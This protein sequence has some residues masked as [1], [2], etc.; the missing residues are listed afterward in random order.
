MINHITGKKKKIILFWKQFFNTTDSRIK[1]C[2]FRLLSLD[3]EVFVK[4]FQ[5]QY[6]HQIIIII[7]ETHVKNVKNQQKKKLLT[8]QPMWINHEYES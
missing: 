6:Y 8:H 1:W 3:I 7:T 5:L 4:K 2:Y